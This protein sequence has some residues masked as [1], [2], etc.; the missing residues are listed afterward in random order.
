MNQPFIIKLPKVEIKNL[1]FNEKKENIVSSS[2]LTYP[3]FTLGFHSFIH[4]TRSAMEITK[5]LQSKTD[6]YYVVN[7]FESTI[8]NF[9]DDIKKSTEL[10]FKTSKDSNNIGNEFLSLWEILF[11]FDV[12]NKS[13]KNIYIL[14]N[15]SINDIID[16]YK[17]KLNLTTK[18]NTIDNEKNIKKENEIDLII[19]ANS[20]KVEDE[21]FIEQDF[22]KEFISY[23]I[24]ILNNQSNEGNCIIKYFD[25]FCIP[26]LK[27]IY[28]I[29]SFYNEAFIYKPFISRQSESE[30][31]L[32]LTGFKSTK[33]I[34][35]IIKMLEGIVKSFDDK[36]YVFDIFPDINLPKDYMS[37]F[38]FVNTRLVNNQQIMINEI[39]KYIKENNYFGDKYHIFRDKQI[40]SSKWWI[41]N[42]YPP[43]ENIYEKNKEELGK[44][45]KVTQE[46]LN[47]ECQKFIETLTPL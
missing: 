29:S 21:N 17:N 27:I 42:F 44:L 46:K 35:K 30:R 16:L 26:T 39:I 12:I 33:N 43:S 7:P 22:Y 38:T 3:L 6:F 23:L 36:N 4:R 31:Y 20:I 24:K 41:K 25:S 13:T 45:Y 18:F 5:N 37:F 1:D 47:L 11:T 14:S 10:Y 32:I 40:E 9:E 19:C 34:D 8:S 15:D 28:L 2:V